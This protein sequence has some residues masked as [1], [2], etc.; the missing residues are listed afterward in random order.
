M[1]D[2]LKRARALDA[3]IGDLWQ[4]TT[5]PAHQGDASAACY[6]VRDMDGQPALKTSTRRRQAA[7][8][9]NM[10]RELAD[11]LERHQAKGCEL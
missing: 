10:L 1:T 4:A 8:A 2:L 9:R 7:E 11:A 6:L 5:C 3:V